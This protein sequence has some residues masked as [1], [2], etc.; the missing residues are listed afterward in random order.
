V[1]L[2]AFG[3]AG[4]Q[5]AVRPLGSNE[6]RPFIFAAVV[7]GGG[8][9]CQPSETVPKGT[10]GIWLRAGTYGAPTPRLTLS[11]T[12]PGVPALRTTLAPGWRE[13]DV[14]V[15]IAKVQRELSGARMCVSNAGPSRLALAGE[16]IN[17]TL[18]ATV[19]GRPATG[20]VRVQY[21][22]PHA[23]SWWGMVP[24]LATSV[25]R[26]RAAFPGAAT[27]PLAI[28]LGLVAAAGAVALVLRE[29][30]A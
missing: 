17:A 21:E 14:I 6:V 11:F 25:G 27:L 23:S 5:R 8:T 16:P 15:P 19:S 2:V 1:L 13:G 30:E 26:V 7:P 3:I 24:R 12:A 18:D 22:P 20:R 28:L 4:A 9:V 10:G 29:D